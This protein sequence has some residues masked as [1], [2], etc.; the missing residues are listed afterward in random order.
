M[1][2]LHLDNRTFLDIINEVSNQTGISRDIIE[3]DYY[4]TLILKELFRNDKNYVFKGGT[5]LSKGYHL[6]NRFS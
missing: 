1:M 6:I 5:S 2:N 4:V 3:K